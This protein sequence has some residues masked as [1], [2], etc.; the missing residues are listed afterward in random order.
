MKNV[1]T[2]RSAMIFLTMLLTFTV[3]L[4]YAQQTEGPK[5]FID[6]VPYAKGNYTGASIISSTE[7][8][9]RLQAYCPTC[10]ITIQKESADYIVVFAAIQAAESNA[11]WNWAVYENKE[12][13]LLKRG[14][15][16]QF[17]NTVKDSAGVIRA[18][19]NNDNLPDYT[20]EEMVTV[21]LYRS[22]VIRSSY[23]SPTVQLNGDDLAKL[24]NKKYLA[25]DVAPGKNVF[26]YTVPG[27]AN[28]LVKHEFEAITG[29]VL[30]LK[31][32]GASIQAPGTE[33][34]YKEIRKLKPE[35]KKNIK[36]PQM[37]SNKKPTE[38]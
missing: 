1:I 13:L 36:N 5:V 28:I 25:V 18:H 9:D 12:G 38:Q 27:L 4:A 14:D 29:E 35:D 3:S 37:I 2:V 11:R 16:I 21:Y 20:D 8:V 34:G 30:Y 24:S 26:T 19:W 7:I 32:A 33:K 6:S 17:N 15:T 31:L 22:E 23:V 10:R